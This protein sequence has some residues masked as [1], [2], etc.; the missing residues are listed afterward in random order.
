MAVLAQRQQRG[1]D[2]CASLPKVAKDGAGPDL[3][4]PKDVWPADLLMCVCA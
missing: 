3:R 4:R 1:F 2:E